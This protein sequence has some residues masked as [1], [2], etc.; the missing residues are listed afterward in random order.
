MGGTHLWINPRTALS[1][2][3]RLNLGQSYKVLRLMANR[4]GDRFTPSIA[5]TGTKPV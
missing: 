4:Q 2:F 5:T 1:A 3:C